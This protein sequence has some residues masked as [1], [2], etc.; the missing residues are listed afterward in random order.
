MLV[1]LMSFERYLVSSGSPSPH[2]HAHTESAPSSGHSPP[3]PKGG[4]FQAL[5]SQGPPCH[6]GALWDPGYQV[7]P[8]MGP[9]LPPP[10]LRLM[11]CQ[12]QPSSACLALLPGFG[13]I[14]ILQLKCNR[15]IKLYTK[16]ILLYVH[17]TV[18]LHVCLLT[19][20]PHKQQLLRTVSPQSTARQSS[21]FFLSQGFLTLE[22]SDLTSFN[23][24]IFPT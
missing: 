2:V 10:L 20:N 12:A 19:R 14:R 6:C 22:H 7:H 9:H 5:L 17:L 4:C 1:A 15:F 24:S 16:S 18:F 21:S 8:H 13:M 23:P 11:L 3:L